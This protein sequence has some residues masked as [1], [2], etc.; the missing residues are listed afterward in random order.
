MAA[1]L[2]GSYV[3]QGVDRGYCFLNE[4]LSNINSWVYLFFLPTIYFQS[5]PGPIQQQIL[6]LSLVFNSHSLLL[7]KNIPMENK[8]IT[9]WTYVSVYSKLSVHVNQAGI[10][11]RITYTVQYTHRFRNRETDLAFWVQIMVM[12]FY[13]SLSV[14]TL[15]KGMNLSFFPPISPAIGKLQDRLRSWVRQSV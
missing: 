8:M 5:S 10:Q 9:P 11:K 13:I 15:L 4:S 6:S 2:T 12:A 7:L 1:S 3:P 14:N